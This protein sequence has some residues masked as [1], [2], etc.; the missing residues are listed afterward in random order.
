[1]SHIIH[2]ACVH[3]I[4]DAIQAVCYAQ[5]AARASIVTGKYGCKHG[6]RSVGAPWNSGSRRSRSEIFPRHSFASFHLTHTTGQRQSQAA[7]S[8]SRLTTRPH[9]TRLDDGM[10]GIPRCKKWLATAGARCITATINTVFHK[11]ER[12]A[13]QLFVEHHVSL[14]AIQNTRTPIHTDSWINYVRNMV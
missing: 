13:S 4:C 3:I 11:L 5:A 14:R 12:E 1:M 9:K 10:C 2:H 7:G 8:G 6:Q